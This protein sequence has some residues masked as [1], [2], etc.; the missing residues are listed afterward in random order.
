MLHHF[1]LFSCLLSPCRRLNS[2]PSVFHFLDVAIS[3][4]PWCGTQRNVY[5]Y[6]YIYIINLSLCI[7]LYLYLYIIYIIYIYLD[8][9]DNYKEGFLFHLIIAIALLTN[10]CLIH[11]S[12]KNLEVIYSNSPIQY[13]R[14]LIFFP[15]RPLT[16]TTFRIRTQVF[17]LLVECS[18]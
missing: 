2:F 12:G 10:F 11:E 8:I 6:T 9:Y 3:R 7:Y 14:K 5:T 16:S 18:F 1:S 13:M 4:V 17:C 15:Q